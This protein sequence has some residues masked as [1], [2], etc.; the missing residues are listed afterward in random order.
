M[1]AKVCRDPEVSMVWRV[2]GDL[3]DYRDYRDYRGHKGS[4]EL[5]T[6]L[7]AMLPR[8]LIL[9]DIQTFQEI[10]CRL[11]LDINL[12]RWV[13]ILK[14]TIFRTPS[15][16]IAEICQLKY[17][18]QGHESLDSGI[19]RPTP[20]QGEKVNWNLEINWTLVRLNLNSLFHLFLVLESHFSCLFDKRRS[21]GASYSPVHRKRRIH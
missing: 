4:Q 1:D 8:S 17:I 5:E 15:L 18:T 16:S 13:E 21:R 10:E 6:Y 14:P 12:Q 2:P 3:R 9:L 7:R 11:M 20:E 19:V